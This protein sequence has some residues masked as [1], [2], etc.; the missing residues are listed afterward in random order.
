MIY[1]D[2]LFYTLWSF[3]LTFAVGCSILVTANS[4]KY[5]ADMCLGC[6]YRDYHHVSAKSI[7]VFSFVQRKV[8]KLPE[9]FAGSFRYK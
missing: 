4:Y 5:L 2:P 8:E 6:G 1:F 7:K 3:Y 9:L